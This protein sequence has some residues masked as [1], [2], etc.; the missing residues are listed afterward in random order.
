LND[1][2]KWLPLKKA[3]KWIINVTITLTKAKSKQVTATKIG[4]VDWRIPLSAA[5]AATREKSKVLA[6]RAM[7]L[8]APTKIIIIFSFIF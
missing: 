2:L 5:K 6:R 4:V 1:V 3:V 7:A 8:K